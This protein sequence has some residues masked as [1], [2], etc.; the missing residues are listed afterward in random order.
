[1]YTTGCIPECCTV[2]D[3][4]RVEQSLVDKGVKLIRTDDLNA[5]AE[6]LAAQTR[7]LRC[8]GSQAAIVG[9]E[10]F[11]EHLK[12]VKSQLQSCTTNLVTS[13]QPHRHQAVQLEHH[14]EASLGEKDEG[15]QE[16][17]QLNVNEP[18]RA[19]TTCTY[20]NTASQKQ[21]EMCGSLMAS[22]LGR[23][24]TSNS[25][26]TVATSHK[27]QQVVGGVNNCRHSLNQCFLS[28]QSQN[29]DQLLRI[30][31]GNLAVMLQA[32]HT[33]W[34]GTYNRLCQTFLFI[35]C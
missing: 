24:W 3:V 5:T 17:E 19:C 15:L 11:R 27:P 2:A 9:Y 14:Y 23:D 18:M 7:V 32:Q 35:L 29:K 28:Q 31:L 33:T 16:E 12:T 26:W 34:A 6:W 25:S 8:R 13:T 22:D 20:L 21:C 1:M 30:E 4:E 10:R